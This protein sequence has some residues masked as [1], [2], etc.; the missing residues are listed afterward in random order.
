MGP[1]A[2]GEGGGGKL[3]ESPLVEVSSLLEVPQLSGK[4]MNHLCTLTL[5]VNKGDWGKCMQSVLEHTEESHISK[6]HVLL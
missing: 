2:I 1:V 6:K 3:P 5:S 4:T